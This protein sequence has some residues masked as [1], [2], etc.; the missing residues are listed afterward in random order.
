MNNKI[1]IHTFR[2]TSVR[3][4]RESGNDLLTISKRLG[5]S[6]INTTADIY[7]ELFKLTDNDLADRLDNYI[8]QLGIA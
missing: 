5:H 7:S 6:S 2:H 1:N 8:A 3:L 4:A